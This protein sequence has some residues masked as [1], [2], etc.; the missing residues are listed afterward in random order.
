MNVLPNDLLHVIARQSSRQTLHC[1]ARAGS[2]EILGVVQEVLLGNCHARLQMMEEK[3][4]L[5]LQAN[6]PTLIPK[7]TQFESLRLNY[8]AIANRFMPLEPRQIGRVL[9]SMAV[10]IPTLEWSIWPVVYVLT[11]VALLLLGI[12]AREVAHKV[13]KCQLNKSREY[14]AVKG[15]L[16]RYDIAIECLK[17]VQSLRGRASV[18]ALNDL[19]VFTNELQKRC[20]KII[21][22]GSFN[23]GI[24]AHR[25]TI[26]QG[27]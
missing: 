9:V 14:L 1:L 2:K 24:E 11:I 26:N 25:L 21:K 15:Y 23:E 19:G 6:D 27:Y 22:E 18:I 8:R 13:A 20:D 7:V 5:G 10:V 16:K 12:C 3:L 17:D 4:R